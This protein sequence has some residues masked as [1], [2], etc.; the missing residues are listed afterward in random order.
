MKKVL[1]TFGALALAGIGITL[2]YFALTSLDENPNILFFIGSFVTIG[3]SVFLL[4]MV[5]KEEPIKPTFGTTIS[6]ADA[7]KTLAKKN[8]LAD[9]YGRINNARKKLKMLE[10]AGNAQE[11]AAS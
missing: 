8:K 1:I 7:A 10:A 5:T 2:L 11:E 9:D 6:E 4:M 3:V